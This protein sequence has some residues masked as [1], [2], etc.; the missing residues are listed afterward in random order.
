MKS[1][2]YLWNICALLVLSLAGCVQETHDKKIR[3]TVNMKGVT[4]FEQ[5]GIRGDIKPLSWQENLTLEDKDRDSI[6][7]VD[8]IVNTAQN[9]LNFKL[10]LDENSFELEGKENRSIPFEY[11]TE[12]LEYITSFDSEE[13]EIIKN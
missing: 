2:I 8:V 6:Y 7:N 10:V 3:I 4:D 1:K 13:F 9:Q 5:V 11:K 12:S